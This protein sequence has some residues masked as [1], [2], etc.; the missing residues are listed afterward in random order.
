MLRRL[1]VLLMLVGMIAGCDKRQDETGNCT[2]GAQN[3]T[4]NGDVFLCVNGRWKRQDNP[5]NPGQR[6]DT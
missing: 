5:N 6:T 1:L 4:A 3:I 2:N